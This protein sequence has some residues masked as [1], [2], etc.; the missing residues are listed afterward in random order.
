MAT[1]ECAADSDEMF[2]D[3]RIERIY[4]L[5]GEGFISVIQQ[6]SPTITNS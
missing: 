4:V 5:G 3:A 1:L 2:Y 6:K